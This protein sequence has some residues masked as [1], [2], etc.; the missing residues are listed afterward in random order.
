MQDTFKR[1]KFYHKFDSDRLDFF[2]SWYSL[3]RQFEFVEGMF[4]SLHFHEVQ[5]WYMIL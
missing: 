2:A 3:W 4:D 5:V 1:N